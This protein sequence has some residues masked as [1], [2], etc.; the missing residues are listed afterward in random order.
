MTDS[1]EDQ[2]PLEK[3][4]DD[5]DDMETGQDPEKKDPDKLPRLPMRTRIALVSITLAEFA[6]G[7]LC[8]F[9]CLYIKPAEPNLIY[10]SFHLASKEPLHD[11]TFPFEADMSQFGV[12]YPVKLQ[13]ECFLPDLSCGSNAISFYR[14]DICAHP[15]ITSF[16]LANQRHYQCSD[17]SGRHLHHL[18]NSE[19]RRLL[20]GMMVGVVLPVVVCFLAMGVMALISRVLKDQQFIREH[21]HHAVFASMTPLIIFQLGCL[22]HAYW[23]VVVRADIP[24]SLVQ[25]N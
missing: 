15:N 8:A 13:T 14:R 25:A 10:Y 6:L 2:I 12:L 21:F 5:D 23:W 24:F 16:V 9:S 22:C 17:I 20:V 1:Q 18:Y 19:S 7:Y 3:G 4:S 11:Y